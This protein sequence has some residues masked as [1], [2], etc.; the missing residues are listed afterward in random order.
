MKTIFNII[1]ITVFSFASYAQDNWDPTDHQIATW[2]FRKI[3]P[4][5]VSNFLSNED[6]VYR[7]SVKAAIAEGRMKHWG[8][9]RKVNG[10]T[11]DGHNYFFYNGFEKLNDIDNSWWSE[12]GYIYGLKPVKSAGVLGTVHTM[13]AIQVFADNPK[14]GN[15]IK[16]NYA[17]PTNIGE[18]I[19]LQNSIWKP[20]IK[21]YVNDSESAWAG[22]EV[23][24]VVSPTG[25]AYSWSV[26][27]VDHFTTLSGALNSFPGG[28][29]WPD[30]I[31]AINDLLPNG[32]FYK[33]VIY[34]VVF[35]EG[36]EMSK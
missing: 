20:F 11:S 16:I 14:P 13:P 24:Q 12:S 26:A 3:S 7:K 34:E 30:G 4:S 31:Q 22:W 17:N 27:T 8:L 1:L 19:Q 25:N 33:S 36:T 15:Y 18:F 5:D 21:G 6:K 29:D 32:K 28:A 9:L 35:Y 2:Q 10:N 23:H